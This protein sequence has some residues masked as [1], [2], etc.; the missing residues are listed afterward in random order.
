MNDEY[1]QKELEFFQRHDSL[2]EDISPD[3][4][5]CSKCPTRELCE[6]LFEHDPNVIRKE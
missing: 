4:C 1:R 2:C 6:W 5:D 3:R